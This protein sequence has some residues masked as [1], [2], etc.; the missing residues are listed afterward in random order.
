MI[1]KLFN[2]IRNW[3]ITG[4]D[5]LHWP[6]GVCMCR[7]Y[8]LCLQNLIEFD[9]II[10]ILSHPCTFLLNL[11]IHAITM[12]QRNRNGYWA[13]SIPTAWMCYG[14]RAVDHNRSSIYWRARFL[15]P[16]VCACD[17][18][19]NTRECQMTRDVARRTLLQ[20]R[21][22]NIILHKHEQVNFLFIEVAPFHLF[23]IPYTSVYKCFDL[24]LSKMT[25][26]TKVHLN[27]LLKNNHRS[28]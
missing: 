14:L 25:W 7:V 13:S 12:Y 8:W 17:V 23:F 2:F 24:K 3:Q 22:I 4:L 15:K 18:K 10:W 6:A 9:E 5:V 16:C 20:T 26:I 28:L 19:L 1:W 21:I 27:I 11:K